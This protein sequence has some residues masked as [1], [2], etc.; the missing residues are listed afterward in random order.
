MIMISTFTSFKVLYTHQIKGSFLYRLMNIK[1]IAHLFK[2]ECY[3]L[4]LEDV[5][6]D[7]IVRTRVRVSDGYTFDVAELVSQS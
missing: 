1:A 3:S 7:V 4:E 2:N 6:V 5:L